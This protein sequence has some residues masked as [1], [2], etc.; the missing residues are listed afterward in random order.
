V[1]GSLL[2]GS[3]GGA[4]IVAP[5]SPVPPG[6]RIPVASGALSPSLAWPSAS[7][8]L[9]PTAVAVEGFCV[10][11]RPLKVRVF[12][13]FHLCLLPRLK[14]LHIVQELFDGEGRL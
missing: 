11:Y 8:A 3:R 9:P 7:A 4:T 12:G 2:L 6:V 10:S 1:L 5:P 13:V 14:H